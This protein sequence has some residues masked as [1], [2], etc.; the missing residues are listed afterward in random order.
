M[1]LFS[2]SELKTTNKAFV[3]SHCACIFCFL[4]AIEL[5]RGHGCMIFYRLFVKCKALLCFCLMGQM[6]AFHLYHLFHAKCALSGE[7]KNCTLFECQ[8]I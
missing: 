8:C 2:T 7:K 3:F 1:S 5:D 6:G 4:Q